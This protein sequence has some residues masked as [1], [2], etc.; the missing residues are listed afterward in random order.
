MT[1]KSRFEFKYHL[2]PIKALRAKSAINRFMKPDPAAKRGAY[3]V[4]SLYFETPQLADYY[5]KSGGFLIRKKIR[6]RIYRPYLTK[7]TPE[8]WLEIKKKYDMSIIKTRVKISL[9]DWNDLINKRF[10]KLLNKPRNEKD[11]NALNEFLWYIMNESRRPSFFIRYK[12]YPYLNIEDN[13]MRVTFDHEIE[14]CNA[15]NLT[16]PKQTTPVNQKIVVMEV[17]FSDSLPAWFGILLQQLELKRDTFSKY[18][19]SVDALTPY[20]PLPR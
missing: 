2:D 13:R 10:S 1:L 18:S 7:E 17:K 3:I 20:R 19:N 16:E 15:G 4:T 8:I 6:A 9:E 14:T 11:K 12:R 5:E